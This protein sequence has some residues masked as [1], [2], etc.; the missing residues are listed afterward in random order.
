MTL[1]GVAFLDHTADVGVDVEAGSLQELL[2]RAALGMLALLRGEDDHEPAGHDDQPARSS[3][4]SDVP[5]RVSAGTTTMLLADWLREILFLHE[6]SRLDYETA[7]FDRAA[8]DGV[9]A[10]VHTRPG[11]RAVREIKGV[12]YHELRVERRP[13]GGW[14]ARVIFDV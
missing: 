14:R 7:T 3:G 12:T 1:A 10:T 2:H 4:G 13:D 9:E 5:V 8:P 11:G 6:I